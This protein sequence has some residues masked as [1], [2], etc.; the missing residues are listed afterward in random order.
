VRQVAELSSALTFIESEIESM[1]P[2]EQLALV[3]KEILDYAR[4]NHLIDL[5]ELNKLSDFDVL[6]L[7]KETVENADE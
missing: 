7:V 6:I 3:R 5:I 2:E 1:E 4:G